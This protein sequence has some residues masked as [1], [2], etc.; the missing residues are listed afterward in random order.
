MWQRCVAFALLLTASGVGG[1]A[2]ER[3]RPNV[4]LIVADDLGY[5]DLG[6]FG[7][8]T[9]KS[10]HLDALCQ[11]GV[12]LTNF[13]VAWPACTPSRASLLTGRFPQRNGLYDMIR[14]DSVNYGHRFTEEEYAV[15]PEM[16][17]GMD[18]REITIADLLQKSGYR[19]GMV[20]KWDGGRAKRFLPLQRGFDSFYGFSNT[21]ID[22]WTHERYGVPSMFRD[23]TRTTEDRGKYAT[24]L[25]RREALAFVNK[26]PAT[27]PLFLYL[28]FNAPHAASNLEKDSYQAPDEVLERYSHL[29]VPVR[30]AKYLAMISSMD[31]AVGE[32]VASLKA[33]GRYENTLFV[34]LSDNGGSRISD[35]GPLRG[36]KTQMFEGGHRVAAFAVWPGVLP[37]GKTSDEFLTA[38]EIFP[39]LLAATG[40]TPPEG[41]TLDGFESLSV[42]KG[43]RA[44]PRREMFWQRRS[45]RA[46]RVGDY[47][48][49][50][51]VAGTGLFH[52]KTDLGQKKDL[53]AQQPEKLQEIQTRFK[54]WEAEM[55]A[56]EPRGPFRDY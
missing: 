9:T 14:N 30:K 18:L 6:C 39:T 56:S 36:Y 45:D 27:D 55:L 4:V 31:D 1:R 51:S 5:G 41:L 35:N 10:P 26:A 47:A 22:Y 48:W 37:A 52:L 2:D 19:C 7:S 20:G 11:Q 50:D 53:S 40:L 23:N 34:F 38:L 32:L 28:A 21:G 25:F 13:S 54:Q 24:D 33:S 17:L 49:V 3:P 44:S 12:R 42:L 16:T 43:E 8:T 29:K 15:S 46:A